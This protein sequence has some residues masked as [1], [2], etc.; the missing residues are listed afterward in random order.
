MKTDKVKYKEA[1]Y[2]L[3]NYNNN[4]KI[5]LKKKYTKLRLAHS[6]YRE[7]PEIWLESEISGPKT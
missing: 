7:L 3:G 2:L 4:E 5:V 6:E 1:C